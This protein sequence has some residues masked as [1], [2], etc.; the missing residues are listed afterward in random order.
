M[1]LFYIESRNVRSVLICID[2]LDFTLERIVWD[3][4]DQILSSRTF[5]S[6]SRIVVCS[7]TVPWRPTFN[8]IR[9]LL[10]LLRARKKKILLGAYPFNDNIHGMQY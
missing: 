10:P 4:I 8:G 3:R 9:R 7:S 1:V 5:A 2:G 6:L